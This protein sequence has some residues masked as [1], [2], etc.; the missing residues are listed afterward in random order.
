MDGIDTTE[1]KQTGGDNL[2]FLQEQFYKNKS[3][4]FGKSFKNKQRTK[5]G[6]LPHRI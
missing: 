6:F 1:E 5:P 4:D 2:F 3:P